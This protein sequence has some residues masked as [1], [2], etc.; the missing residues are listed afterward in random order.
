[1]NAKRTEEQ[2]GE[3][4]ERFGVSMPS[5]L[6]EKFDALTE[7]RG[8]SNRSEAIRDLIRESLVDAQWQTGAQEVVGVVTLVYRHD[9]RETS[10]RLIEL[11]HHSHDTVIASMHIHLDKDH[12]LEIV[13]VRGKR[14]DVEHLADH[15]IAMRGVVHGKFVAT[16]T[17]EGIA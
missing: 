9:I 2:S 6:L 7:Q 5:S 17:G 11:Q 16:T 10:D 8:Y 1:M 15:L 4:L 14:E 12:C 3:R 13:A